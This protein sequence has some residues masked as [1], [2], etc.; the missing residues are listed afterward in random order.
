M[1]KCFSSLVIALVIC[2][3][4]NLSSSIRKISIRKST[5]YL[6]GVI[7]AARLFKAMLGNG[8][9]YFINMRDWGKKI[10]WG[11]SF[12]KSTFI[13]DLWWRHLSTSEPLEWFSSPSWVTVFL[14]RKLFYFPSSVSSAIGRVLSKIIWE[15]QLVKEDRL[16]QPQI[17]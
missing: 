15:I 8:K 16:L 4:R 10:L 5:K 17:N 9:L 1:L 12:S 13:T 14:L 11:L 3:W 2:F 6:Q 7:F